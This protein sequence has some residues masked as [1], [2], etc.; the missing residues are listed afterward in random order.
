MTISTILSEIVVFCGY[1]QLVTKFIFFSARD[2]L[3]GPK[4]NTDVEDLKKTKYA[5]KIP[6]KK[7]IK[8]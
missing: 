2:V 1:A 7:L 6:P 3:N 8:L 4:A 5:G